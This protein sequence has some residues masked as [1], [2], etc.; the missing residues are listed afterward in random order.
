MLP[1]FLFSILSSED[2]LTGETG[3]GTGGHPVSQIGVVS[4]LILV[5]ETVVVTMKT[6]RM[7]LFPDFRLEGATIRKEKIR[8]FKILLH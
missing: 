2:Y 7:V 6:S 3:C 5:L 8:A 4:A 1:F